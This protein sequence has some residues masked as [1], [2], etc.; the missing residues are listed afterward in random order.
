MGVHPFGVAEGSV[1]FAFDSSGAEVRSMVLPAGIEIIE[2][3]DPSFLVFPSEEA[4]GCMF[5]LGDPLGLE[6][7][8]Y[9]QLDLFHESDPDVGQGG[10]TEGHRLII[11]FG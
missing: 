3:E 7:D 4:T 6:I 5:D 1:L 9:S 11:T 10:T 8:E 2:G